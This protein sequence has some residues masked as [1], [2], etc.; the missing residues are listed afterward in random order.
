MK[1]QP[2]FEYILVKQE[3]NKKQTAGGILLPDTN[4][5]NYRIG[6]IVAI[7]TDDKI[8]VKVGDSIVFK[9]NVGV[10]FEGMVILEQK[11]ILMR[12]V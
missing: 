5:E 6:K 7:G 1:H 11:D 9:K 12:D 2:L 3:E 8:I 4:K 10:D